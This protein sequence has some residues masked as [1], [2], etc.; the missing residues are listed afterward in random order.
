M[1]D[2]VMQKTNKIPE[3]PYR[4][5]V[6]VSVGSVLQ[7]F[8]ILAEVLSEPGHQRENI[9]V[10]VSGIWMPLSF[11]SLVVAYLFSAPTDDAHL[12]IALSLL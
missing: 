9:D 8:Q 6:Y 7:K 4:P 2:A 12:E 3:T 10:K 5:C 1:V 11:H